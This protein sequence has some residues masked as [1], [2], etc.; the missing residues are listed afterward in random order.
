MA[1]MGQPG[2]GGSTGPVPGGGGPPVPGA[3]PVGGAPG[4]SSP[5]GMGAMGSPIPVG[6]GQLPPEILTGVMSVGQ[7]IVQNLD[8]LAQVTPELGPD[9]QAVKQ[10]LMQTLSKLLV[11]GASPASPTSP[12]ASAFPGGGI[13]RGQLPPSPPIA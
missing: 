6:A 9:W 12:G 11:S 4:G 13:D 10:L 3:S 8:G 1:G 2:M 7:Q 5:A